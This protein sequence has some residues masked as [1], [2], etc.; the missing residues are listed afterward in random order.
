M[1]T[2]DCPGLSVSQRP[3]AYP[4]DVQGE[5]PRDAFCPDL[6]AVDVPQA[7]GGGAYLWVFSG[8]AVVL[9]SSRIFGRALARVLG[10]V[11]R[12]LVEGDRDFLPIVAGE[13]WEVC[14]E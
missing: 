10:P 1:N 8:A 7:H 2:R 12:K 13:R 5:C 4:V 11:D 9:L 14:L 6:H 3:G